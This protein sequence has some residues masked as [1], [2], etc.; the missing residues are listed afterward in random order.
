MV[1]LWTLAVAVRTLSRRLV[2]V[3]QGSTSMAAPLG[4]GETGHI[5]HLLARFVVSTCPLCVPAR[6]SPTKYTVA[7][8]VQPLSSGHLNLQTCCVWETSRF[9]PMVD[10]PDVCWTCGFISQSTYESKISPSQPCG[11]PTHS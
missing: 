2:V 1:S 3:G 10:S 6:K 9:D 11:R 7:N 8:T 5:V 4:G